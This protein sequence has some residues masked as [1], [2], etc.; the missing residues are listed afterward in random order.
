MAA[1]G[2]IGRLA[3]EDEF[4]RVYREGVRRATALLVV[5]ARPNRLGTVRVGIAVGRRFGRAVRRNRLRRRL[6]EAVR[7]QRRLRGG[8]DLVVVP[9]EGAAAAGAPALRAALEE[10]LAATGLCGEGGEAPA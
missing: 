8:V 1:D 6:R 2:T 4:R 9:R 5:H 10:A 3:R 7:A